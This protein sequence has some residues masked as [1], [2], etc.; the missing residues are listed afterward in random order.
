MLVIQDIWSRWGKATRSAG[1]MHRRPKLAASYPLLLPPDGWPAPGSPA[2]AWRHEIRCLAHEQHEVRETAGPI[3]SGVWS[4]DEIN[5]PSNL[6]WTFSGEAVRLTLDRPWSSMLRTS[7][8]TH[9]PSPLFTLLPGQ[10]ARIDWNA[11][12]ASSMMGSNRSY[13]YEQHVC[14]LANSNAPTKRMF[15]DGEMV[16]HIN[17]RTRIY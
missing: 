3:A 1:D 6:R 7:W 4:H 12:C 16:K 11:R 14:W 13:F 15:E 5:H 10:V 17:L 8:P 2:Q 9:L